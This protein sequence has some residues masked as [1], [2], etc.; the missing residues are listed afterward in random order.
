[1]FSILAPLIHNMSTKP[2]T[3]NLSEAESAVLEDLCAR[4]GLNKSALLRQ[5][6]RVYQLVDAKLQNG[7]KLFFEDKGKEKAEMILV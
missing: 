3:L 1:M 2:I 6:L 5:A 4:R 7:D